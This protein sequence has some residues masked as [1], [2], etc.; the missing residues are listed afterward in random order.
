ME[1]E[2]FASYI[3]SQT[4]WGKKLEIMFYLKKKTNIYYNNA[5]IFKTLISK[6]FTE[7]LNDKNPEMNLDTNLIITARLLCDCCKEE[8]TTDQNV[9]QN[10][11]KK[12]AEYLATLGFDEH[13]CQVCEGVNRYTLKDNRPIESDILELADQFGGLVLDRPERK[14]YSPEEAID[15]IRNNNLKNVDNK[16]I[17]QFSEFVKLLDSV[18]A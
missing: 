12:G 3:L 11:A 4:D 9:I 13:F 17:N 14:G 18:E 15:T 10:Y 1:E 8:D 6:M 5:V 2:S 7:Y 16:V